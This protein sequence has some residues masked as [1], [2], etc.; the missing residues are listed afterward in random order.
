MKARGMAPSSSFQLLSYDRENIPGEHPSFQFVSR[1]LPGIP[2]AAFQSFAIEAL[3]RR[4]TATRYRP[5]SDGHMSLTG[6]HVNALQPSAGKSF[7]FGHP[8]QADES[9][10]MNR[11]GTNPANPA[12]DDRIG[13]ASV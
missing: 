2:L 4:N 6:F 10:P 12:S 8:E 11:A 1:G 9:H 13:L 5:L 7:P 3:V